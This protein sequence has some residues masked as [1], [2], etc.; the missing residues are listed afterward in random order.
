M[1]CNIERVSKP[2]SQVNA[3]KSAALRVVGPAH[4]V[5]D[6]YVEIIGQ[7]DEYIRRR[8]AFSM[9][10]TLIGSKGKADGGGNI[11]L[12]LIPALFKFSQ[13]IA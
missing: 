6:G 10:I 1:D 7:G 2:L 9:F 4:E 12:Q 3:V 13:P 8:L 5:V 11:L